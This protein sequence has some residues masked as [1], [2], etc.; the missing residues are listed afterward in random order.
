MYALNLEADTERVLSATFPEYAPSDAVLVEE[1][2]EGNVADY[3]YKNGQFIY[4]PLSQPPKPE[5]GL[6]VWDELDKAYS[7]G[8]E[9]GYSE[10]VNS[11]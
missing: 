9:V 3:L 8:Y 11:I 10:G 5:I 4:D 2:P 1:L 6:S 7:S